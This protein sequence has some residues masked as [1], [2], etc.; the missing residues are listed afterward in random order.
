MP[1]SGKPFR[2]PPFVYVFAF[3][4]FVAAIIFL[5]CRSA[6]AQTAAPNAAQPEQSQQP[7]TPDEP[8]AAS[9]QAAA[10]DV[11]DKP[12]AH[13][14]VAFLTSFAGR[15][16]ADV[17][18]DKQ[19]RKFV[20]AVTPTTVVHVGHDRY[21]DEVFYEGFAS[22]GGPTQVRDGRYVMISSNG[23]PQHPVRG[24]MWID[25][26]EGD[27]I[28]AFYFGPT[29]GEPTPVLTIFS[30]QLKEKA[31]GMS[32]LPEAF[33]VDVSAWLDPA[34][35]SPIATRY[36]INS[37]GHKYVLEHDEDFC[38]PPGAA[39]PDLNVCQKMNVDASDVDMNAAY[40]MK[41]TGNA[42]NATAYM[43]QPE[44]VSFIQLREN[45]CRTGPDPLGC[46]IHM[47]RERTRTITGRP[48]RPAPHPAPAPRR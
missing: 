11:F 10:P 33:A 34:H 47:T 48:P 40:F 2:R 31:L 42:S 7:P 6:H 25:V 21:L 23:S 39:P 5:Q 24:F 28:G 16:S 20:G 15:T 27:A 45:T 46:H 3:V 8:A 18:K 19:F 36:F 37:S 4:I 1:F 26:Q 13:D 29:N 44:Q 17:A 41:A 9:A 30:R 14:N 38:S 43:L 12:L 22:P 35:A 32:D